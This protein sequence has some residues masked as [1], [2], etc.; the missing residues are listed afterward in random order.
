MCTYTVCVLTLINVKAAI[1][2]SQRL[3]LSEATGVVDKIINE[4]LNS[5]SGNVKIRDSLTL[6]GCSVCGGDG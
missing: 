6:G 1:R 2:A 5:V 3:A 4:P